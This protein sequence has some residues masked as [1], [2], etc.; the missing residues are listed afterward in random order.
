MALISNSSTNN[1]NPPRRSFEKLGNSATSYYSPS[2]LRVI[3]YPS[4]QPIN[5]SFLDSPT[6]NHITRFHTRS[7]SD[8]Y[9]FST[10]THN[11]NQNNRRSMISKTLNPLFNKLRKA[12][13]NNNTFYN[14]PNIDF[15]LPISPTDSSPSIS[16]A[17][18]TRTVSS[19]VYSEPHFSSSNSTLKTTTK[20]KTKTKS[21]S[22]S[23][24]KSNVKDKDRPIVDVVSVSVSN[25]SSDGCSTINSKN[26]LFEESE[27][28]SDDNNSI[29]ESI[30]D[31]HFSPAEQL[32]RDQ[33][34]EVD[35]QMKNLT[36][37]D[38]STTTTT[39]STTS[40]TTDDSVTLQLQ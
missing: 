6:S 32:L 23:K 25:S 40:T 33:M 34:A 39:T 22:K 11:Q 30:S 19:S 15:L 17:R 16:R 21:K 10:N 18:S 37:V 1:N 27:S 7:Q 31:Y 28:E 38:G 36:D 8:P 26:N 5:L 14:Q 13:L 12:S 4:T 20:T 35:E 29:M 2:T 3:P 9:A 24:S